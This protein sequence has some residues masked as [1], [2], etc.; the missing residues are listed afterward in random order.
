MSPAAK[1]QTLIDQRCSFVIRAFVQP[2]FR[3]PSAHGASRRRKRPA[4]LY[5]RL[6]RRIL[7]PDIGKANFVSGG[8]AGDCSMIY[9]IGNADDGRFFDAKIEIDGSAVILHSRGG[10]TG[11][12]PARNPG[13]EEALITIIRR[14][15]AHDQVTVPAIDRVLLDSIRARSR[16]AEER[17][18]VTAADI[19][20]VDDMEVVAL[21]RKRAKAWGQHPGVTGGNSTKQLRI[22]TRDRSRHSIRAT[23]RLR[24]WVSQDDHGEA[25]SIPQQ[26]L[27]SEV[28]RR[29]TS[30]QIDNAVARL[31]AGEE[32]PNFWP[33]RDY[34][35]V[36]NDGARLAPKKVFALALGEALGTEI[37]PIHFSAGWGQPCFELIQAAG[38]RIIA[39]DAL[40]ATPEE[41]NAEFNSVP[42]SNE[43]RTY[44]EGD[45]RMGAHLRVERRRDSRAA[46]DKRVQMIQDHGRLLCERC[47]EDYIEQ[48]GADVAAGCFEIHHTIPLAS[49]DEARETRIGELRCL[50][51]TCHRATHR[52][53]SL[54]P[55]EQARPQVSPQIGLPQ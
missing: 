13:Y 38:Y 9:K 26:R 46:R 27:A 11:G 18:L 8:A 21:I 53:M 3:R 16:S 19:A 34:D 35:V 42:P 44:I 39:K 15:R 20:G 49:L 25:T 17:V 12:R 50:C 7:L 48:F 1:G 43:D 36:A 5:P 54:I 2:I 29:V 47:E 41:V 23:L 14:L 28:Q 40:I 32:A 51:A 22:E 31:L 10:A 4:I 6:F 37:F 24:N 30:R 52:E 55:N 33:S 45:R